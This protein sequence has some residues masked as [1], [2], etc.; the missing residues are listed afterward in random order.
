MKRKAPTMSGAPE[1]GIVPVVTSAV[2]TSKLDAIAARP[3]SVGLGSAVPGAGAG[4]G[5]GAGTGVELVG[6]SLD[7]V[8]AFAGFETLQPGKTAIR[9]RGAASALKVKRNLMVTLPGPQ[10]NHPPGE[11]CCPEPDSQQDIWVQTTACRYFLQAK[12]GTPED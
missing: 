3:A 1:P 10:L 2:F 5:A 4:V 9:I 8:S 11:D 7:G 6:M 12:R